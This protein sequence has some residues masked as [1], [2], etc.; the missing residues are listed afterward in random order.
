MSVAKMHYDYFT[1]IYECVY[2]ALPILGLH[3]VKNATISHSNKNEIKI[4]Q[5]G[6]NN[7]MSLQQTIDHTRVTFAKE[8]TAKTRNHR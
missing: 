8:F 1:N 2:N 7:M 4:V 3:K 6:H 5:F